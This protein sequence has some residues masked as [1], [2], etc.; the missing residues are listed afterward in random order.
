MKRYVFA[1]IFLIT[2]LTFYAQNEKLYLYELDSSSLI[3]NKLEKESRFTY[4]FSTGVAITGFK[5]CFASAGFVAPEI[6]YKIN[7]KFTLSGGFAVS[8]SMFP[9]LNSENTANNSMLNYTLF[10]KGSYNLTPKIK[11]YGAAAV[12]FNEYYNRNT[13]SYSGFI[14]ADYKISE[15]STISIALDFRKNNNPFMPMGSMI[16][17]YSFDPMFHNEMFGR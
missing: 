3:N 15:H 1:I 13:P 10:A 17:A 11:V 5:D 14:G 9:T 6:G 8:Y 4:N 12:S 7:D 16:P 2:S